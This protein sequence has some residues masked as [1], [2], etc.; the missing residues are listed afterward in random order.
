[1]KTRTIAE[2][3]GWHYDERMHVISRYP[4]VDPPGANGLYTFVEVATGEVAAIAN[5]HLTATPYGPHELRDGATAEEVLAIEESVRLP[6]V[7]AHV[8]E[9]A[10]RGGQCS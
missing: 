9:H 10:R 5:T 8:T 7:Q 2:R 6:E 3:L 1:M 4:L